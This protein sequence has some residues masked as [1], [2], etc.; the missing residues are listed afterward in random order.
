MKAAQ[1][2]PYVTYDELCQMLPEGSL[3]DLIDGEVYRTP[4][5]NLRH[6]TL[7]LRLA[8][9]FQGAIQDR[10]RVLIAPI[11]V[12][13]AADAALQPDV[14]LVLE[15]NRSILQDVVRGV[16]DLVLEVLSPSTARRDKSLKME[17]Y[18]RHGVGECWIVSDEAQTVEV[19]RL[20]TGTKA[21]RLAETCRPGDR[22]ATPLL[23]AL[24]LDVALLFA[25]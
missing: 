14:I 13:L 1:V 8:V 11:D 15:K 6:Q 4:S 24:S 23:T 2:R 18:A 19:Y 3:Y 16:P 21:Y 25:E 12:V 7:V 22:A 20:E 10:S 17:A 5:P 9:A